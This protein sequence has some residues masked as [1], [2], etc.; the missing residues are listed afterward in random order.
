MPPVLAPEA[1][2]AI[3][4]AVIVLVLGVWSLAEHGQASLD[5]FQD[6]VARDMSYAEAMAFLDAPADHP[7]GMLTG[8]WGNNPEADAWWWRCSLCREFD[9]GLAPLAA[10]LEASTHECDP[11]ALNRAQ[12]EA[13]AQHPAHRPS[14][15]A[16]DFADPGQTESGRTPRLWGTVEDDGNYFGEI[17]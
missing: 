8:V 17:R 1:T 11:A 7:E 16:G 15:Q 10:A 9:H 3:I 5:R 12:A 4:V 2:W 14:P 6:A 13:R